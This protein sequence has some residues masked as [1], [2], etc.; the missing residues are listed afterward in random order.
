M[1]TGAELIQEERNRQIEVEGWKSDRDDAYIN[2]ELLHASKAY[3]ESS[4][5]YQR[6]RDGSRK[7]ADVIA[8]CWPR[9]WSGDWFKPKDPISDLVKSGAL[10]AAEID[11]L[12]RIKERLMNEASCPECKSTKGHKLKC[13]TGNDRAKDYQGKLEKRYR[14]KGG[15]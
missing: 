7:L 12:Q 9:N 14:Q 15:A 5:I 8:L 11:R 2:Q 13:K 6:Y 4:I 3:I 10:I 1:K